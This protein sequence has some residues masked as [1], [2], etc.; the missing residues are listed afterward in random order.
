MKLGILY[1]NG[2]IVSHRSLLKV[3]LNPILRRFGYFIGSVCEENKIK[4]L[5]FLKGQKMN[6]IVYNFRSFKDHD[7]VVR[8]RVLF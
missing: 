1:K 4:G 3:F 8:K 7:K 5:K 2:K 6:R